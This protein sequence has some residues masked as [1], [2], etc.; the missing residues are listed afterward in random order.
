MNEYRYIVTSNKT[1]GTDCVQSICLLISCAK[2]WGLQK[3][4]ST[5]LW[6]LSADPAFSGILEGRGMML[7]SFW[8]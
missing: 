2:T 1:A 5:A 7:Q 4:V 8:C 6:I 3:A